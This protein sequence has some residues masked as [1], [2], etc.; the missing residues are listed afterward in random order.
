MIRE[1]PAMPLRWEKNKPGMQSSEPVHPLVALLCTLLWKGAMHVALFVSW[2][3]DAMGVHK[4]FVN[5]IT[6][7]WAHITVIITGTDAAFANFYHLRRHKDAEPTM[8]ALADVM[9][10]AHRRSYPRT[11]KI[12]EWHLPYVK[13][14]EIEQL[15]KFTLVDPTAATPSRMK[16]DHL[17]MRSVARCARVSYLKPDD[18]PSTLAEDI[19]LY[20]RLVGA[21]PMHA[22][23][24]E[25]QAQAVEGFAIA[26]Q[27]GCFGSSSGWLQYRK[28][29]PGECFVDLARVIA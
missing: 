22:S 19:A 2:A 18:K 29:L 5:R 1:D 20:T 10:A 6:E 21:A 13:K 23:P 4:Q 3:L 14:E 17:I 26:N 24:A 7:P 25:H 27:G 15:E 12:G 28:T 16:I 11:L 8:H 9:A